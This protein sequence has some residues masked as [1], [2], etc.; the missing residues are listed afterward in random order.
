MLGHRD[1]PPRHNPRPQR[2]I[3]TF[4]FHSFGATLRQMTRG[5]VLVKILSDLLGESPDDIRREI[6]SAVQI[7]GSRGGLDDEI[8][9]DEA[10][11]LFAEYERNPSGVL[12]SIIRWNREFQR[13]ADRAHLN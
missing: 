2:F 6:D 5:D 8:S 9:D 12:N 11:I 3:K 4:G 10:S 1:P 7:G 13:F